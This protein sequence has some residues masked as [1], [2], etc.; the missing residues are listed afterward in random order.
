[1][2]PLDNGGRSSATPGTL[3]D[4]QS[5][6]LH[7]PARK[8]P[9]HLS[10]SES[11]FRSIIIYLTVCTHRR[12]P[13]LAN[14]ESKKLIL[15]AWRAATFWNVGR[16]VIMPDHIHLFCAPNT[17]TAEPLKK[18]ISFWKNHVTRA[19]PIAAN[20]HS[21]SEN[22]GIANYDTAT[23]IRQ[24]GNTSEITRSAMVMLKAL[25]IGPIRVNS[26]HSSGTID[27]VEGGAPRRRAT[28]RARRA[29]PSIPAVHLERLGD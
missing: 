15:D 19:W 2:M 25:R 12:R 26:T 6:R 24:N 1:M 5:S 23:P 16:Y 9:T 10:L 21:G 29:R 8:A 18:W 11:G 7:R 17:L 27:D 14:E 28:P 20:L 4:S 22:I 3:T 13:I